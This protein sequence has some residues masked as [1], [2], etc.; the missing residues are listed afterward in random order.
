MIRP[1]ITWRR[2][3][4]RLA[5]DRRR[6]LVML[7]RQPGGPPMFLRLHPAY[8]CVLLHRLSHY[9]F[10]RRMGKAG[11][12]FNQLNML[13]TGVDIHPH[14]DIDGGLLI[15]HPGAVVLSG[16]AGRNL[17]VR[18]LSG[19]G[20]MYG[21]N[22]VG[23]G[24]GLPV[25]GNDVEIGPKGS[26]LGAVLI[27]DRVRIGAACTATRDLP[28]DA[29]VEQV[30]PPIGRDRPAEPDRRPRETSACD[31]RRVSAF[32]RDV[33]RDLERYLKELDPEGTGPAGLLRRLG[34]RLT[35]QLVAAT[36]YRF[37]HLLHARGWR[38][39]ALL[40][41]RINVLVNKL[42]ISPGSCIGGGLF[43]PHPWGT[44]FNGRAGTGL[45]LFGHALCTSREA[46]WSA[47]PERGPSLGEDVVVGAHAAIIGPVEV[48]H[49]TTIGYRVQLMDDA[50][51]DA[52]VLSD[53][54]KVRVEPACR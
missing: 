27:G 19:C 45:S 16:S 51:S 17:T 53:S 5:D 7:E 47:P 34:A 33:R 44:V 15:P 10:R 9:F 35:T 8:L 24:P 40:V 48:G 31:H 50:P 1:P 13:V 36:I 30:S 32:R 25:L 11:R 14:C 4:R 22:D 39:T 2:T 28:A 26:V 23:A 42:T 49:R 38:R 21:R 52:L 41:S 20:I 29:V 6:L 3:R 18:A 37:S 12:F 46:A 43:L 54:M